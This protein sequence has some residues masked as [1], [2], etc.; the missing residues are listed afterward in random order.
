M[1]QNIVLPWPPTKS[2]LNGSQ[3]DFRGKAE[4]GRQYKRTC[5]LECMAQKVRP[6]DAKRVSVR[7]IF[8]PPAAAPRAFDWD[9]M[10]ARCKRGFDAVADAI[11]VD[12]KHWWPVTLEKGEPVKG[13]AVVI[14]VTP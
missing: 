13:G 5:A 11:G 4:A 10:A 12:D 3:G 6:I 14:E 1:I 7:V 9:N 8:C 2:S